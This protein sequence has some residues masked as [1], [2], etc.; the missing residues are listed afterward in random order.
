MGSIN[1]DLKKIKGLVFDDSGFL[2][3][4]M[5][6]LYLTGEP[7]RMINIKDGYALQLAVKKGLTI[8]II[9]GGTTESVRVRFSNLGIKH[10][11]LGAKVKIQ[12]FEHFLKETGLSA[13][14][15]IYMGDDIPDFEVMKIVGLP[16]CPADAS[17]DIKAVSKYISEKKGGEGCA[18][19]VIEQVMKA[20]GLW[21][22]CNQAFGW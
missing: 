4:D 6:P 11:Y 12:H 8:G 21:M 13:D 7:M 22:S 17:D 18:R 20:Q 5:V 2:S 19:D 3:S 10:L 14:E 1:L 9:T 16:V 15:V